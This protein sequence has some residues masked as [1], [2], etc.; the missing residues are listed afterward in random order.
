MQKSLLFVAVIALFIA[1]ASASS[2]VG[3]QF[4]D[5]SSYTYEQFKTDYSRPSGE[6]D[7]S[8]DAFRRIV[9]DANMHKILKHNLNYVRG[10]VSWWMKPTRFTDRTQE[11]FTASFGYNSMSAKASRAHM[12]IFQQPSSLVVANSINKYAIDWS[13]NM[14]DVQNQGMFNN[15]FILCSFSFLCL[16]FPF[17]FV[18]VVDT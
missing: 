18:V 3:S 12:T 8:E 2:M 13:K 1:L 15:I 6:L 7:A 9:F 10:K 11:E 14:P 16:F 17:R 4:A 5:Y